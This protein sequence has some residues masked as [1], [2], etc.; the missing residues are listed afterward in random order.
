MTE[1]KEKIMEII[2]EKGMY[3]CM[4][5]TKWRE[6]KKGI[7]ALPFEPPYAVKT[8]NEEENESHKFGK[9]V[10]HLGDWG[11]FEG[12]NI[13]ELGSDMIRIPF[14]A[15]EWIKVRPRY[16]K[17]QGR[18]L[19]EVI[20]EDITEDFLAI[21]IKHNIPYEEDNGAFIIHGYRAQ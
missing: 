20:V 19:P 15:V 11:D 1:H 13:D 4:N 21:L 16:T 9:D 6:L 10:S 2:S 3:S 8:V 12:D 17:H 5:N 7:E 18:L 14:Y